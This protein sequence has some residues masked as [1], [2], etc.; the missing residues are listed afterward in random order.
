MA[1]KLKIG[2]LSAGYGAE[3]VL[4]SV[5]LEIEA[6]EFVFFTGANGSGKSTLAKVI[7]GLIESTTGEITYAG[8]RINTNIISKKFG[9]VPQYASIER[10][11]PISVREIIELECDLA[12]EKCPTDVGAHLRLLQGEYL[13]ERRI[14]DLSGGE[15]QRILIA[16]GLVKDPELIILDEPVNNLDKQA[17]DS[18]FDM[19]K[20]LNSQGKTIIVVLHDHNLMETIKNRKVYSFEEK[21]VELL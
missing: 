21:N 11:F 15:L 10:D 1:D 8:Q 20:T 4:D 2:Q 5:S 14:K 18:L 17:R 6:G 3:L 16:R 9:Y 19:L 7:L 13:L 12:N